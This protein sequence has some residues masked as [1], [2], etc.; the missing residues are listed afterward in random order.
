ML[1]VVRNLVRAA[2]LAGL[3]VGLWAPLVRADDAQNVKLVQSLYEAFGKGDVGRIVESASADVEWGIVG[4]PQDCPCFGKRKGKDG[5]ADF[6]KTVG[7][8]WDFKQFS[9]REFIAS[10]DRVVVLG[11]YEMT[12]RTTGKPFQSEWTHVFLV[13]DGK[14]ASFTEFTDTARAAEANRG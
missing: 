1:V 5:V 7:A 10:G 2:L 3:V 9:P 4:R 13:K 12:H 11:A 14:I 8:T 6:F